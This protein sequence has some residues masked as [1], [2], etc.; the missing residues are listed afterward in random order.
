[1][2]VYKFNK[3]DNGDILLEKNIIDTNNFTIIVKPNGDKLLKKIE[4]IQ[5][6]NI[7]DIK[8]FNFKKSLIKSCQLN[9]VFFD[10]LKYKRILTQ[11]Y[12]S[13][14]NGTKIIKNTKLNI[15][16]VKKQNEGFYHIKNLGISVQGV[17]SNKCLYEIINQCIHNK[18]NIKL[19]ITLSNKTKIE[20]IF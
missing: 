8:N 2:E 4:N 17:D 13:I 5:I 12:N 6:K 16:T 7:D 10:K 14:D 18:I 11:I 20:L 15:K 9:N 19:N 3:L 1:M